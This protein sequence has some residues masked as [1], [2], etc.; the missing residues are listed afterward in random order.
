[1]VESAKDGSH[2]RVVCGVW[3]G[4]ALV[5]AHPMFIR[6]PSD[7]LFL[8][9][10]V[11]SLIQ[12]GAAARFVQQRAL[13]LGMGRGAGGFMRV[14]GRLAVPRVVAAPR[15]NPSCFIVVHHPRRTHR[16]VYLD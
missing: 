13:K 14:G 4:A 15:T 11:T 3:D 1:M 10:C 6:D 7:D 2:V 12:L 16:G 8:A 9:C 5:F